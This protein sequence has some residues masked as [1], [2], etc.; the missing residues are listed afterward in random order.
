MY[1]GKLTASKGVGD[2][3][4]ALGTLRSHDWTATIVGHGPEIGNLRRQ[5]AEH[6]IEERVRFH[7]FAN[8]SEM[9]ELLASAD[10]LVVPSI[11]DFRVLVAS[12]ALV[13]GASVVVSTG[14]AVWGPGDLIEDGVTGFVFPAGDADALAGK[15]LQLIE[16]DE[17]RV[18]L[19]NAGR[20][21]VLAD[22]T[23]AV[24]ARRVS[25]AV[26]Q[27]AARRFGSRSAAR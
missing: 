13:S 21:R 23:P 6:G 18:R 9:P 26:Q 2:F 20:E 4:R 1:A 11:Y 12:E 8:Q 25:Q 16:S 22:Q 10:V 27:V 3:V 5:A 7:G 24:F 15:L 19:A 17:L 14:T